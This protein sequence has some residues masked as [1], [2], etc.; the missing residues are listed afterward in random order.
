MFSFITQY[1]I[2]I[3]Y[4][5]LL[6]ILSGFTSSGLFLVPI[7]LDQREPPVIKSLRDYSR[8]ENAE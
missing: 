4:K 2:I 3:Y 7:I 1:I 6:R 5:I 8:R